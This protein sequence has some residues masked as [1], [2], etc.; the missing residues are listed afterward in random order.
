[1]GIFGHIVANLEIK[2]DLRKEKTNGG[3]GLCL[4][5]LW[6][7]TKYRVACVLRKAR[8]NRPFMRMA[9]VLKQTIYRFK[10]K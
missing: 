7:K 8:V 1:M 10:N 5:C 6:N 3:K 9:S 4:S 2:S